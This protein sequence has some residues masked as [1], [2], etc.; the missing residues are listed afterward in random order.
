[1]KE[2]YFG[3]IETGIPER[4]TDYLY[5]LTLKAVILNDR[6]E[7]LMVKERGR[8]WWG[9][10]GG[11]MDHGETIEQT[12][13]RELR[14]EVNLS[15]KFTYDIIGIDEAA[16]LPSVA[17]MQVRLIFWVRPENMTFEPGD[18]GDEVKFFATEGFSIEG[19]RGA[20]KLK[21]YLAAIG[22]LEKRGV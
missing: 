19:T 10:P 7:I 22:K 1:M 17:I 11:G 14:E 8:D 3:A 15:G 21:E 20:E 9:L 13:A 12:L 6:G 16:R 2:E 18:D 4:G 5:R